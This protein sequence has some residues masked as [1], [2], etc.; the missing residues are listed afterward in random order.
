MVE[1][2]EMRPDEI[3]IEWDEN[4]MLCDAMREIIWIGYKIDLVFFFII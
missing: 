4:E 1:S 3:R 2:N